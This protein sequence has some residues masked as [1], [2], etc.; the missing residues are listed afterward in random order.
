VLGIP[1]GLQVEY[2][3]VL[4]RSIFSVGLGKKRINVFTDCHNEGK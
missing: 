4:P 1:E 3:K 2:L